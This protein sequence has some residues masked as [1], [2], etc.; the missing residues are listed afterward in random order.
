MDNSFKKRLFQSQWTIENN[1][2]AFDIKVSLKF[3][4]SIIDT[5]SLISKLNNIKSLISIHHDEKL[6]I[7]KESKEIISSMQNK[8]KYIS[9]LNSLG[10]KSSNNLTKE[11]KNF[12]NSFNSF[13]VNHIDEEKFNNFSIF[14]EELI[15]IIS[16]NKL[17]ILKKINIKSAENNVY[18]K[19]FTASLQNIKD[20]RQE[21]INKV[22]LNKFL[23]INQTNYFDINYVD[24]NDT[25]DTNDDYEFS[26]FP[27]DKKE[28]LSLK[29]VH[30]NDQYIAELN[31]LI[32]LIID[33]INENETNCLKYLE[34]YLNRDDVKKY[35]V[36]KAIRGYLMERFN[37]ETI[38][39]NY[40][41][42][43][44]ET[45]KF[46]QI[47]LSKKYLDKLDD[48]CTEFYNHLANENSSSFPDEI[49]LF[50]LDTKL[51]LTKSFAYY[52]LPNNSKITSFY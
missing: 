7:D 9:K 37:S 50:Y 11:S 34:K 38:N 35:D 8:N 13:N 43:S 15:S 52:K 45:K 6:I 36:S 33:K 20:Q 48:L 49:E 31:G 3:K 25:S 18:I 39:I 17:V 12:F 4:E 47:T 28:K 46:K 23:N 51:D 19:D 40:V 30:S 24:I 10:S 44:K 2:K 26:L 32:P 29:K 5:N 16:K 1:I 27:D 22:D 41:I 42:I 21:S 14:D